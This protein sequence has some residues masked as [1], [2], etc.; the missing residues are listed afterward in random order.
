MKLYCIWDACRHQPIVS[1]HPQQT[2]LGS[3]TQ[4]A[5]AVCTCFKKGHKSTAPNETGQTSHCQHLAQLSVWSTDTPMHSGS[6]IQQIFQGIKPQNPRELAHM[7]TQTCFSY[8]LMANNGASCLPHICCFPLLGGLL[9]LI[10][11][12]K[13]TVGSPMGFCGPSESKIFTFF[14]IFFC[15]NS[16]LFPFVTSLKRR[17]HHFQPH[18]HICI[19]INPGDDEFLLI[20]TVCI[21][22]WCLTSLPLLFQQN[23]VKNKNNPST[24]LSS[25]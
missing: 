24:H 11:V 8:P 19:Y 12:T 9:I 23:T 7:D 13:Y 17:E 4:A 10:Y 2:H 20:L 18:Q 22:A 14:N 25:K 5:E 15:T 1:W 21:S 6:I 3:Q 16:A